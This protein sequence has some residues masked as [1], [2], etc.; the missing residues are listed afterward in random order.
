[1][2]ILGISHSNLVNKFVRTPRNQGGLGLRS[3]KAT[4][5]ALITKLAEL[6]NSQ[7]F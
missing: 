6:E 1:M 2:K 7:Q 4:N 5:L 3:M